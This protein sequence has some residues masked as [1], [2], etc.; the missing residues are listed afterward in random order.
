VIRFDTDA[1]RFDST[2]A[3]FDHGRQDADPKSRFDSKL[4]RFDMNGIRFD[5]A[6][7]DPAPP[8]APAIPALRCRDAAFRR[9]HAALRRGGHFHRRWRNASSLSQPQPYH[10]AA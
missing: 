5:G 4:L 6:R 2:A 1:R 3:R 8:P 10:E 9:E 7:V